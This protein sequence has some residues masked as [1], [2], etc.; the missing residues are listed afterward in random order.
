MRPMTSVKR[1]REIMSTAT[2]ARFTVAIRLAALLAV[3]T[4][5]P[6]PAHAQSVAS[7]AIQG[8][9]TDESAAA[10]PGVTVT[11]T[12]P[13]LQ[14]P[15]IVVTPEADGTYRVPDLPSGVY[16]IEY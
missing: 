15:Q 14:V 9:L 3:L 12:G 4:W 7:G 16:Q 5:H 8:Q 1:R 10:L 2:H 11:V 6:V 13:A